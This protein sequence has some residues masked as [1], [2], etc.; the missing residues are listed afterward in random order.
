VTSTELSAASAAAASNL[1]SVMSV[2]SA[3]MVSGDIMV[4]NLLSADAAMSLAISAHSQML[5]LA[6]VVLSL[7]NVDASAVSAGAP[8]YAFTSANTFKRANASA[9]A[10]KP[11]IGLVIDGSV[12]VS[13]IARV[14]TAGVVT[15][16]TAQWDAITGGTGGL[17]PGSRYFLDVAAGLLTITAPTTGVVRPVGIALSSTQLKLM[18]ADLDDIISVISA[19]LSNRVSAD[20]ALSNLISAL[21]AQL[22]LQVSALSQVHSALSANVATI[23]LNVSAISS[24]LSAETSDRISADNALS[25]LISALSVQLSLQISAMSQVH[26]ALSANV[27]TISLN[28]SA[29]STKISV[30][31]DA[32]TSLVNRV[33]ANSGTGGAGSVT[34]TELSA[35]SAAAASNLASVM[36]ILSAAMVSGDIA[37]SNLL[38]AD[39]ALSNN[40]SAL[41]AQLSL[42]NSAL[43][44]A[45]S[46]LSVQLSLQ[47]SAMSQALSVFEAQIA[48]GGAQIRVV[49]TG[50]AIT[51]SAVTN[52]SGLSI[53]VAAAGTYQVEGQVLFNISALSTVGVGF[54]LSYPAMAA[55]AGRWEG[56]FGSTLNPQFVWSGV[57]GYVASPIGNRAVAYFMESAAAAQSNVIIL[58]GVPGISA[59]KTYRVKVDGLFNVSANG[60][61]Q[62]VC[63]QVQAAI[64]VLK[65][66]FIRA[67]KIV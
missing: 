30:L 58:S 24:R 6:G 43:S 29:M 42:D 67:Y 49:A 50:G 54:G 8:V 59:G 65:G 66:S 14:Q 46:V 13:A 37:V 40:I 51:G 31:S 61:L 55:A 28:A 53:S 19:E 32:H 56:E 20:N 17:T 35:A 36:S 38:S 57:S 5:S 64:V 18:L 27:A 9:V 52:I 48:P 21:S 45:I 15:L 60:T 23:S 22:S 2:L 10:T 26:S 12:A 33:S 3:A 25:N 62:V 4:S 44:Q 16:T 34:S 63:K 7:Q 47:V 11:V 41:S 39:A 1:A